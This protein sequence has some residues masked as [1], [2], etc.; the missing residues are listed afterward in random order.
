MKTGFVYVLTNGTISQ[1]GTPQEL[2]SVD[3]Y[4]KQMWKLKESIHQNEAVVNE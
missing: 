1:Q 4:F 3:G 2:I